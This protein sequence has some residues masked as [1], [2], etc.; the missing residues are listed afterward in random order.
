[1]EAGPENEGVDGVLST[2]PG[3]DAVG[4]DPLDGLGDHGDV[5]PGERRVVVVRD[6]DPLA[7]DLVVRCQ[8][9]AE[10]GVLDLPV[11]VGKGQLLDRS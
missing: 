2:V 5:G 10:L 3:G 6:Q 11:H 8:L 4:V 1:M 7:A 9:A